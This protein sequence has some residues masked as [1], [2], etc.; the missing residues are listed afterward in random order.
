MPKLQELIWDQPANS[1]W[2]PLY[3]HTKTN[4]P[5]AT[6]TY[7]LPTK[8]H[9]HTKIS[10]NQATTTFLFF[11]FSPKTE[12]ENTLIHIEGNISA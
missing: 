11:I 5:A 2:N 10:S 3:P 7:T 4:L 6:Q 8:R 9:A 12:V 1:L